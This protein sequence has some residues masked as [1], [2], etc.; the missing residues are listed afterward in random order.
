MSFISVSPGEIFAVSKSLYR[1]WQDTKGA[2]ERHCKARQ[3]AIHAQ[4]SSGTLRDA[5]NALGTPG[6]GLLPRLDSVEKAYDDLDSYL[7]RFDAHFAPSSNTRGPARLARQARWAFEQQIDHRVENL[8]STLT[9]ALTM[10]SLALMPQMRYE[11]PLAVDT[12]KLISN[13][14]QISSMHQ[15]VLNQSVDA[16]EVAALVLNQLPN[17][18]QVTRITTKACWQRPKGCYCRCHI[19]H[20][21]PWHS[22]LLG[23]TGIASIFVECNWEDCDTC[24]YAVYTRFA[25][26]YFG[27]P[28]AVR[29]TAELKIFG[30]FLPVLYPTIKPQRVCDFTSPGFR[31]LEDITEPLLGLNANL[32]CDER[33]KSWQ[34]AQARKIAE[35]K[36]L[37]EDN[38]ASP[39]D[40]DPDGHSWIEVLLQKSSQTRTVLT[41]RRNFFGTLGCQATDRHSSNFSSSWVGF[42]GRMS[43]AI[44]GQ[45]GSMLEHVSDADDFRCIVAC[46]RKFSVGSA[47]A[48]TSMLLL[49]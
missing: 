17:P 31:L 22:T 49:P 32:T 14:R 35:F 13:S 2:Q 8:Q 39:E 5:C 44:R 38:K 47:K 3:F 45:C 20:E 24:R 33:R 9:A 10:C 23:T 29:F 16:G 26:S 19:S 30:G 7:N 21:R 11:Y 18:A 43:R 12:Q 40:V 48:R 1:I 15:L 42:A 28:F 46:F 34:D 27:I 41:T 4:A 36:H 25:L 37:F 6:E